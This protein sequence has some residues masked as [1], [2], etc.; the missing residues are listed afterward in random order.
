VIL[1][2]LLNAAREVRPEGSRG[3]LTSHIVLISQYI[4][5]IRALQ[6]FSVTQCTCFC[7]SCRMERDILT[8]DSPG[9]LWHFRGDLVPCGRVPW[10]YQKTRPHMPFQFVVSSSCAP[11]SPG[12]SLAVMHP[13]QVRGGLLPSPHTCASV[14]HTRGIHS[15]GLHPLRSRL[16]REVKEAHERH[17]AG[18]SLSV[19]VVSRPRCRKMA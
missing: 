1:S 19:F 2:F 9:R 8:R 4:L 14:K 11:V 16:P 18:S 5:Y 17:S 10:L 3:R 15:G 7:L 13:D 6:G 12:R